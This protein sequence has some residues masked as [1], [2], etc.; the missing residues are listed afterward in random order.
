MKKL[1]FFLL[2]LGAVQAKAQ[3][4]KGSI[5][6]KDSTINRT[7]PFEVAAGSKSVKYHVKVY[8]ATGSLTI[9]MTDP[10]NKKSGGFTLDTR[11]RDGGTE[12]SK[13]ELGDSYSPP[14]TGTWKF[15]IKTENA[16]GKISY[17]IDIIRP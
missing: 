1:L 16:T 2:I 14:V 17:Q 13:G 9:T 8:V 10:H 4:I 11:T 3:Q 12:P 7:I 6:L 5:D 15:N